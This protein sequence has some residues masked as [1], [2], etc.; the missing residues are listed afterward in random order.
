MERRV[1]NLDGGGV[2]WPDSGYLWAENGQVSLPLAPT[3]E[4]AE[5]YIGRYN[6]G[7]FNCAGCKQWF[8]KPTTFKRFAG[9]YCEP[10]AD[11]YKVRHGRICSLC[12][13]PLWDCYC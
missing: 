9:Q 5:L 6:G 10:C 4:R 3:Q 7:E 2:W 13:R 11:D 1:E 12:Q 8:P